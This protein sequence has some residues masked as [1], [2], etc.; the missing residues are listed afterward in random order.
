[1]P[2][3]PLTD[4][5]TEVADFISQHSGNFRFSTSIAD[6]ALTL[7]FEPTNFTP[8]S[9]PPLFTI[10]EPPTPPYSPFQWDRSPVGREEPIVSPAPAAIPISAGSILNGTDTIDDDNLSTVQ[11][12]GEVPDDE[13]NET[14]NATFGER[15]ND[16]KFTKSLLNILAHA[17]YSTV[18]DSTTAINDTP[19]RQSIESG[20]EQVLSSPQMDSSIVPAATTNNDT[21]SQA[22]LPARDRVDDDEPSVNVFFSGLTIVNPI[23][24]RDD[25]IMLSP[26]IP[27]TPP[28]SRTA[29]HAE[30]ESEMPALASTKSVY[31]ITD[32]TT[33]PKPA[34]HAAL[35]DSISPHDAE[36][37]RQT[38]IAKLND[39]HSFYFA[40]VVHAVSSFLFC[41]DQLIAND[42]DVEMYR[43]DTYPGHPILPGN[44]TLPTGGPR[45]MRDWPDRVDE[46][47]DHRAHTRH[48]LKLV[49]TILS[50]RMITEATSKSSILSCD[51]LDHIKG[52][53]S[54]SFFIGKYN[55]VN[56]FFTPSESEH[57]NAYISVARF[58]GE[59]E[60][61]SKLSD[62]LLMPF[63]DED[64]VSE[65]TTSQI[66]DTGTYDD[67]IVFARD[68]DH[69]LDIKRS[70]I[71][72]LKTSPFC[73][74]LFP[75]TV[76]GPCAFYVLNDSE[77]HIRRRAA[78]GRRIRNGY[79]FFL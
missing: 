63:P 38:E 73:T 61:A 26:H 75:G 49:D 48:L 14:L 23:S 10:S 62:T 46:L 69:L 19:G 60:F 56:P 50:A 76:S 40:N 34:P 5:R 18:N 47:R 17:G 24:P 32:H 15:F 77:E 35:L 25:N 51:Q 64:I 57:L 9:P 2:Y 21:P 29:L 41:Q 13:F 31:S 72:V 22:F 65:L 36:R 1:M 43:D 74:D 52:G 30:S 27:P 39:F 55:D 78:N 37:Y 44:P 45:S 71:V 12:E 79:K 54:P 16:K 3:T 28:V 11:E 66:L 8:T 58:H 59:I 20:D 68:L 53:I 70:G 7:S 67:I 4:S 6:S 33:S 42:W